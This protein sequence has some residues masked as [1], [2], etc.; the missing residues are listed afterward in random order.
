M[1]LE[2]WKDKTENGGLHPQLYPLRI[3]SFYDG[4]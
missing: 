1:W 2:N 4:K 3:I